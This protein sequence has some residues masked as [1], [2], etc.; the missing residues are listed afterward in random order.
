MS[1][2]VRPGSSAH[3]PALG[4]AVREVI[5]QTSSLVVARECPCGQ[6]GTWLCKGCA[7]RLTQPALRVESCCEALQ[8]LSAARVHELSPQ[9]PAGV[10]HTAVLPVLAL[11]EYSGDLQR[12]ILAWKNGGMLHLGR[13][14]APSLAPA[15]AQ[16]G[17]A[18]RVRRPVLVPVSS[19]LSARLRRGEDHTAELVRELGRVG[20][21][22][23]LLLR[24]A[25]T[26]AQDGLTAR[27]RRSRRVRLARS[28]TRHVDAGPVVI[29]DDVVTTGSTLRGMHT[30]L[31][32]AGFDVLG[33]V[34]VASARVPRPPTPP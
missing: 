6:E 2:S 4:P 28:A 12:L 29:I 20:A 13:R 15:V 10:D 14:I 17:R 11:G 16:F 9:L 19:R 26:T 18:G 25:P 32:E 3:R 8:D 1:L 30:A 22:R 31:T 24:S 33:A 23:P 7:A 34:V 5:A 27:Q 21:G